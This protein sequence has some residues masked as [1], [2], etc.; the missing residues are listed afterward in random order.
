MVVTRRRDI[1]A[2]ILAGGYATR[3]YPVTLNVSKPLLAIG[4]KTII[5]FSLQQLNKIKEIKEIFVITNDKFYRDYCIWKRSVTSTKKITIMSDRTKSEK[6]KLGSVGDMYYALRNKKIK[7]DLLV[8]GGDNI[9]EN[10]LFNFVK[11]SQRKSPA[12]S[13]GV[14]DVGSKVRAKRYGVV[15]IN[16]QNQILGFLEKPMRP[17]SSFIAMCLYFFPKETLAFFKEYVEKL[18]LDTDKA[19]FYIRWLLEKTK[20][21]GFQFK[22]LWLDI[23]QMDTYKKA[24]QYFG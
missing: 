20:M 23:G 13:I 22:G 21:Y 17:P 7:N 12:I 8:I 5:D 3:L 15:K 6:T 9:F 18:K 24:Q 11:F 4:K 16:T 14:Y 19:G 2:L 10:Y 1:T